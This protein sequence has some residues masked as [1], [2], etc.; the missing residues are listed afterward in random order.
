MYT[1]RICDLI[2]IYEVLATWER[3]VIHFTYLISF[4]SPKSRAKQFDVYLFK[5]K[6]CKIG[7]H[8]GGAMCQDRT[9]NVWQNWD[10]RLGLTQS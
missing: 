10:S 3:L 2:Y 1:F 6:K 9:A 5:K 8:R 7:D 4:N